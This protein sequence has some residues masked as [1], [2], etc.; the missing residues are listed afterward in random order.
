MVG[1]KVSWIDLDGTTT[2]NGTISGVTFGADG[3]VFDIDGTQVPLAQLLSV[4][5]TTPPATPTDTPDSTP[6][7][8]DPQASPRTAV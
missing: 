8:T 5:T 7:S 3:P 1:Q 2:H 4:G 6:D